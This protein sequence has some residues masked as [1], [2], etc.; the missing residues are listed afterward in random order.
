MDRIELL[1]RLG[2]LL[3]LKPGTLKPED[4]LQDLEAWDSLAVMGF[5]ALADEHCSVILSPQQLASCKTVGDLIQLV[6]GGR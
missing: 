2:E 1:N 3:E 6:D 5:I 4:R